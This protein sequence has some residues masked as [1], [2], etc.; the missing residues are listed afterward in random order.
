MASCSNSL[1]NSKENTKPVEEKI[2]VP[3]N[4]DIQGHRG[5]RGLMPENTVEGF[6]EAIKL[7][8][9][10]IEADVVVTGEKKLLFSHEPWFSSDFTTLPNHDLLMPVDAENF[11]I[12]KMKYEEI[13]QFDVGRRI[14]KKFPEQSHF[15]AAKPLFKEGILTVEKYCEQH[16]LPK[17]KYNI[18]IKAKEEWDNWMTP[19][20][21]EYVSIFL[22]EIKDLPIKDRLSVQS[23]DVRIL[24]KL[25]EKAPDL[26]LVFLV[27]DLENMDKKLS[28][29][30]FNPCVL[31]PHYKNIDKT[32][33]A[34]MHSKGMKV[35]PWTVN[36]SGDIKLVLKA[37]VDG[38]I[39]DYP[40][41]VIEI[42]KEFKK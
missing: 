29:L 40:N 21:D 9:N 23:F 28:L 12:Y 34:A 4:F 1:E 19:A 22:N 14:N 2:A 10:T 26:C 3:E 11:N 18:E 39:S 36:D 35:I 25:H 8:V 16:K 27:E 38:I 6:I 30:N 24:N 31:S 33:V 41:R 32:F 5:M 37:G 17:V 15:T 42:V 20:P 13:V 7:G